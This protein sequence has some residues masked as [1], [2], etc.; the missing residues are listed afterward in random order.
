MQNLKSL[1]VIRSRQCSSKMPQMYCICKRIISVLNRMNT[2]DFI[3][4]EIADVEI[5]KKVQL[6]CIV[7]VAAAG[8]SQCRTFF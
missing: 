4:I 5:L 3:I 2:V 1:R 8:R 6:L 7:V